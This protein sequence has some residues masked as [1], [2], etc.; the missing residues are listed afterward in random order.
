MKQEYLFVDD[1]YKSEIEQ[2]THKI[3]AKEI[4]NIDG[5]DCWIATFFLKGENENTANILSEVNE[6]I[7]EHFSPT[8]LSS[9]CSAYYNKALYPFFNEFERKLRKLLYLKTAL[10]KSEKDIETI[11]NVEKK[12][13]GEIFEI[14]FADKQFVT[15]VRKAINEKTWQFTKNEVLTTLQNIPEQTFWDDTIGADIV[16]LLKSDFMRVKSF[17][18]DVMHAHNINSS[19]FRSARK[20][21]KD[22][23]EQ[24]D[25]AIQ[26]TIITKSGQKDFTT[27]LNDAIKDIGISNAWS[28]ISSIFDLNGSLLTSKLSEGVQQ[29]TRLAS[30]PEYQQV[31]GNLSQIIQTYKNIAEF[32]SLTSDE[33][34]NIQQNIELYNS[35]YKNSFP[36]SEMDSRLTKPSEQDCKSEEGK[37]NG[38]DEN[39]NVEHDGSE[40]K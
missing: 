21:L 1:K 12:D 2:Y 31:I 9:G 24:L 32:M 29:Y 30:S 20:L 8:V 5:S 6:Y 11:K 19:A 37:T 22:V 36:K 15:N 10:S 25:M 4:L 17:R 3:V 18:N 14:L 34:K 27:A 38:Q 40:H 39:G 13:L 33:W 28:N 23:N 35:L 7:I 16:P 26:N